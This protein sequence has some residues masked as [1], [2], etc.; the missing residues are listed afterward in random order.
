M[1]E[2]IKLGWPCDRFGDYLWV[3]YANLLWIGGWNHFQTQGS[4]NLTR[5]FRSLELI[6][7]TATE[8]EEISGNFMPSLTI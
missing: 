1:D 6:F 2:W 8:G 3:D 7:D 4:P 5:K